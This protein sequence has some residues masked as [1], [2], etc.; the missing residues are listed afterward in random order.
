MNKT[1]KILVIVESPHKAKVISKI[2]KDA[3]YTNSRTIASVGHILTL[4]DGNKKAFNS[5]IYPEDSFRMNLKIAED[6]HKVVEDIKMQ[7]A[8][9]DKIFIAADG[10][11]SGEFIS[12]SLLEYAKVPKDN[13]FRMI[14]H[15][16][17]PKAVLYAMENP[18]NFDAALVN[19]EKARQ[20]TDKLLGYGLSPLGKK[21]MG[22]KSIGRCQSVGLMLVADRE[23]EILEFIPEKYFNLYL[24]FK[25]NGK[26]FK[27]KYSGYKNE[28]YDKIKSISEIKTIKYHCENS[29]YVIENV[30]QT[31]RNESPKQ[32]FCTATFQQEASSRLGIKVKDA[33]SIAQKLYEAGKI[34]YIRTDDTDMSPEFLSEL[35]CYVEATYGKTSYKGLRAKKDTGTITQNGHE[36]LRVTDP[37]LTPELF[38]KEETNNLATKV[39]TLIWQRTI[40]SVL[41]NAVYAETTNTINNNDHKFI[42][43]EKI[44][45]D[46][47]FR[48][49]YSYRDD[50]DE[51][52]SESFKVGDILEDTELEESAKET[53]PPPRFSE[54]SLVK[55]LQ[56]K[57]IGRPATYSTIVETILSPTRGYATLEEKQIVPTSRGLQLAAYCKR[58]FP[59]LINLNYTKAMEEQL[60][61]IASGKLDWIDYLNVFYDDL[62]ETIEAN[63]ETGL[64]D[65]VPEKVCPK[66]GSA[67]VVRRSRFGK[68]FYGCPQ[69]PSCNGIISID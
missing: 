13:A 26:E 12:W 39:Y 10:D 63:Q 28:K 20:C 17:T 68:L 64:A 22:A 46:P 56:S 8:W 30:S 37:E 2:L 45:V 69:W 49:V 25:K 31:K 6:K 33:M 4:A 24:K 54:A 58:A 66:C 5:G 53:T 19:A 15:E 47:G 65:D 7:V 3:G 29:K 36:C 11:R 48:K 18:V 57:N 1:D 9:A 44:L 27:A 62:T 34:S 61:K 51:I 23:N 67:M 41:P 21:H 43:T 14:M 60:D 55:E 40:A 35:K 32:P 50:S 42:L 59:K 52:V 38:T 16:I